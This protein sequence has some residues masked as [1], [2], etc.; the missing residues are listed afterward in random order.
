MLADRWSQ[1][2]SSVTRADVTDAQGQISQP[3]SEDNFRDDVTVDDRIT[4][5]DVRLIKQ[6]R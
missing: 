6:S 2:E 1:E 5:A 4:N 3:V